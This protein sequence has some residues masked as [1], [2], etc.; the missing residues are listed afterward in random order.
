MTTDSL[1]KS[2]LDDTCT[3]TMYEGGIGCSA[4]APARYNGWG[5]IVGNPNV[6]RQN[7]ASISLEIGRPVSVDERLGQTEL[8]TEAMSTEI[9]TGPTKKYKKMET[10]IAQTS[11]VLTPKISRSTD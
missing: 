1:F 10:Q 3:G 6:K 5:N 4:R 8:T 11:K 9:S 7:R 2:N